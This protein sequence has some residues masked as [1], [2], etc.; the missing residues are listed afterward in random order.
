MAKITLEASKIAL[1]KSLKKGNN[2]TPKEVLEMFRLL[3]AEIETGGK[4]YKARLPTTRYKITI[5]RGKISSSVAR[6]IY[7]YLKTHG[8][9]DTGEFDYEKQ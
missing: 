4:H 7:K 1:L 6:Q 2:P 3:Q 8:V 5:P 9:T